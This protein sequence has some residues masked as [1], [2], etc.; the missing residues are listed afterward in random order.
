MG[1]VP[2]SFTQR[3]DFA[4][5]TVIK[6]QISEKGQKEKEANKFLA[7]MLNS[8]VSPDMLNLLK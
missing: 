2:P 3:D 6:H 4:I 1:E 5:G 8:G 7:D